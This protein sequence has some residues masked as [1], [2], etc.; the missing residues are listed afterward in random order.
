MSSLLPTEREGRSQFSRVGLVLARG[1][2]TRHLVVIN[3][4]CTRVIPIPGDRDIRSLDSRRQGH[5]VAG[6]RPRVNRAGC[7]SFQE[8]PRRSS[9]APVYSCTRRDVP[10]RSVRVWVG[11]APARGRPSSR[12]RGVGNAVG[13]AWAQTV[14]CE[15]GVGASKWPRLSWFRTGRRQRMSAV[16]HHKQTG[17]FTRDHTPLGGDYRTVPW[18]RRPVRPRTEPVYGLPCRWRRRPSDSVGDR[19]GTRVRSSGGPSLTLAVAAFFTLVEV[20]T[21]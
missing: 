21:V 3:Y 14:A 18:R 16:F 8:F 20:W 7:T 11:D 15:R 9:E 2:Q 1:V 12:N 6:G 19:S 5:P 17:S 10:A 13:V 4:T